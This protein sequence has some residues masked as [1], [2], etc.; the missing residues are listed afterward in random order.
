MSL[1]ET[2]RGQ[3]R[4]LRRRRAARATQPLHDKQGALAWRL[5]RQAAGRAGIPVRLCR[6]TSTGGD[7]PSDRPAAGGLVRVTRLG[8]MGRGVAYRETPQ[9]PA[10][11][12]EA[13]FD[14]AMLGS[15][16]SG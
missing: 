16:E 11:R 10:R 15:M 3:R 14:A 7:Q 1:T 5:A 6:P 2:P 4:I 9:P 13:R 8:D 12:A